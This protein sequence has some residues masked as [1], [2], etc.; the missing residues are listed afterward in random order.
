MAEIFISYAR[1]TESMAKRVA[2]ALEALGYG[3]WRDD[4]LPAHLTYGEVIEER[5]HD[6]KVV[7]TIWSAEATRS[8][9]VRAEADF[10]RNAGKLVQLAVDGTTPPLPFNQVQCADLRGWEGEAGHPAW[11]KVLS[12]IDALA[13]QGRTKRSAAP[14]AALDD[15]QV[16]LAV[17][18]FDNFSGDSEMGFF[19]DGV[20]EEILQTVASLK[21]LKVI[22]RSSSFQFRG[23]DKAA[24]N[25]AA[26]L[27]VSHVLDGSVRRSGGRVR[28]AASLVECATETSLW[29]DRFDRDLADVFALQD[30]IAGAVAEAL[31]VIFAPKPRLAVDPSAYDAYLR[32]RALPPTVSLCDTRSALLEQA[33]ARAPDFAPAWSELAVTLARSVRWRSGYDEGAELRAAALAAARKAIELD[34]DLGSPYAALSLLQPGGRYA[35]QETMLN[36]ARELSGADVGIS[37]VLADFYFAVGRLRDS[38]TVIEAGLHVDPLNPALTQARVTRLLD[39]ERFEEGYA[40]VEE[41]L[42]KWPD[43]D[44]LVSGPMILAAARGEDDRADRL[45]KAFEAMKSPFKE[46]IKRHYDLVRHPDDTKRAAARDR[47]IQRAT[48]RGRVD[49]SSV[50]FVQAIGYI[51]AAY[52]LFD[53]GDWSRLFTPN[54]DP[55]DPVLTTGI[56]F[57]A[58]HAPLRLDRRFP[59]MCG[60]LGLCAYWV[61][62]GSWP[63]CA[64]EGA[65]PYDF[66]EACQ[67]WNDENPIEEARR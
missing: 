58:L 36:T 5:L 10:A 41:A 13:G 32:A 33:V 64:D 28:V 14:T 49:L 3:V 21:T 66:R 18:A 6:A 55:A 60:R 54:Q 40:G 19:S 12:S 56:L 61:A 50:L 22:G 31:A 29:S 25:V 26:K 11:R 46:V 52:D 30:E 15:A 51:D 27:N 17:L 45:F 7:L 67:R 35:A 62:S 2:E 59:S 57:D 65:L 47:T 42:A 16:A 37:E 34:P 44:W 38:F 9:W 23:G 43:Q 20:S 24:A 53:S 63:D 1:A 39:L 4:Q 48:D 8:Q